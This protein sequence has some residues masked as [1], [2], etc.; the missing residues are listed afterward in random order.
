MCGA[1]KRSLVWVADL[2]RNPENHI[3]G[4]WGLLAAMNPFF[5]DVHLWYGPMGYAGPFEPRTVLPPIFVFKLGLAKMESDTARS[6]SA[7]RPA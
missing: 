1:L 5:L 3:G 4:V 6:S 7:R 2:S